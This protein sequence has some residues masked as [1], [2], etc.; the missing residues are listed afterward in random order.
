MAEYKT[1]KTNRKEWAKQLYTRDNMTI[2][3]IAEYVGADRRTVSRWAKEGK[4]DTLRT[5]LLMTK[6]A[7]LKGLYDGL[8]KL[9]EQRLA[10]PIEEQG[11][12]TGEAATIASISKSIER[13]ESESG[14]ADIISV[15][16]GFLSWL[17][18]RDT[19]EAKR[20]VIILDEYVKTK[21]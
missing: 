6:E 7:Q 3:E 4:W 14:I 21:G 18:G 15:F 8:T 17:R 20:L 11:W 2:I 16:T 5:G 1:S 9:N 19:E 12:T 10:R 13:L